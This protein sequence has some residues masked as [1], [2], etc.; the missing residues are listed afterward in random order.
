MENEQAFCKAIKRNPRK[1][2]DPVLPRPRISELDQYRL[3]NVRA[4][5]H[6][7]R[8]DY[9]AV[10]RRLYQ[11]HPRF[12]PHQH[13]FGMKVPALV[14]PATFEAFERL[15]RTDGWQGDTLVQIAQANP[16][17]QE[18]ETLRSTDRLSYFREYP[19]LLEKIRGSLRQ[20]HDHRRF[21]N[22]PV[23]PAVLF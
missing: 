16:I 19:K 8:L 18:L 7:Y 22:N 9:E 17:V 20:D 11:I 23:A 15:C 10:V 6:L 13:G 4:L 21:R 12:I 1:G 14:G 5:V 3:L 2:C